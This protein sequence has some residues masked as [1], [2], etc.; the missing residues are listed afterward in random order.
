MNDAG[1]RVKF[2]RSRHIAAGHGAD[3]AAIIEPASSPFAAPYS[4]T[5]CPV[6]SDCR[7]AMP[8][9]VASIASASVSDS[10]APPC[11]ASTNARASNKNASLK[12]SKKSGVHSLRIPCWS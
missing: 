3:M 8:M 5:A 12:R 7:N 10:G 11:T 1:Q 9:R 6:C 4:V 2:Y